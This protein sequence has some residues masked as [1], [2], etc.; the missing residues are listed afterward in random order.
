[1]AG[2]PLVIARRRLEESIAARALEALE[3]LAREAARLGSAAFLVG[4][5][6]RDLLLGR[7]TTDLDVVVEGDVRALAGRLGGNVRMH[8]Q[9]LTAT[10]TFADGLRVDVARARAER[11]PHRAA[12]PD[13]RPAGLDEDLARRDFTVNAMA[14]RLAPEGDL[15]LIDPFAG[16]ADVREKRIRVLHALSFLEDP[17]RAFRALRLAQRLG[18][19]IEPRTRALVRTAVRHGLVAD[20]SAARVRREL[21]TN[22]VERP[23]S[24][25]V[26]GLARFGIWDALCPD[27]P[28]PRGARARVATLERWLDRHPESSA[29]PRW[30]LLL[31]TL[32]TGGSPA[33]LDALVQ[34][35][36]PP[37][38]VASLLREGSVATADL[39][40]RLAPEAVRARA[41]RIH[42]ACQRHAPAALVVALAATHGPVRRAIARYLIELRQLRPALGARDLLEA[43]VPP[44]PAIGRGLRAA[45]RAR[46]DGKAPDRLRQLQIALRA[47]RARA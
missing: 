27:I 26:G 7:R 8:G 30:G 12:L 37:R 40:A 36:L 16:R 21:A 47:A 35:L 32:T 45:L 23:A 39:A 2:P 17:T 20:L 10:I 4:G 28:L 19:V 5:P 22:L 46:L 1:M 9:F 29:P 3:A 18:F 34:R 41:S 13:V 25:A 24:A 42:A 44:G 15:E 38:S 14:L 11:Y 43:G 33:A 6:V 31:A